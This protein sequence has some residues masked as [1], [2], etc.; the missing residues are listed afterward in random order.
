MYTAEDKKL[1]D[2]ILS[3]TGEK[4]RTE[5]PSIPGQLLQ[6]CEGSTDEFVVLYEPTEAVHLI[7]LG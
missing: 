4:F 1:E 3:F 2:T 7:C 5:S 6:K